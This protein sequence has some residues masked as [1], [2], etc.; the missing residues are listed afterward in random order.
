MSF[1]VFPF[2]SLSLSLSLS[3]LSFSL[4]T[5]PAEPRERHGRHMPPLGPAVEVGPAVAPGHRGVHDADG[6]QEED[7][8]PDREGP[9]RG[10]DRGAEAVGDAAVARPR[11]DVDDDQDDEAG[12]EEDALEDQGPGEREL[13]GLGGGLAVRVGWGGG[14]GGGHFLMFGLLLLLLLAVEGKGKVDGDEE[15]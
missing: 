5:H 8:A 12:D 3:P 9:A 14:G 7:Q 15:R 2:P 6:L 1:F 4:S 13:P 11:G 10:R